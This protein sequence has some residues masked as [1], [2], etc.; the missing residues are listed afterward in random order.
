MKAAGYRVAAC[1]LDP[2]EAHIVR[3]RL[4]ADGIAAVLADD[5]LLQTHA[6]LAPAVGG[7]RVLVPAD[8]TAAARAVIEALDEGAYALDSDAEAED[9]PPENQPG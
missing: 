7:V 9:S 4:E 1:Y 3:A 5:H 2:L 6:L 8:Q